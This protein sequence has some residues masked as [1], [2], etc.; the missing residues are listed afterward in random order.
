[1]DKATDRVLHAA[2][3]ARP[4]LERV[5]HDEELRESLKRA[6]AAARDV[7]EELAAPRSVS[8][9]AGRVA[10]DREIQER[11]RTA[12]EELRRAAAL[13]QGR[14]RHRARNSL[15]LLTGIALGILFNP[16]T[17]PETRRWL[18][19]QLFGGGEGEYAA[20][21]GNSGIPA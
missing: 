14:D 10:T 2:D 6:F 18:K 15:L 20:G 9:I 16:W 13:A 1:M 21:D 7:Y 3:S 4:Y 19:E 12:I 11:L 5:L 8:S 17:G